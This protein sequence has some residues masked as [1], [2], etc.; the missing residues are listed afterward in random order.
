MY[1]SARNTEFK[2]IQDIFYLKR[3]RPE[4]SQGS[5]VFCI[6]AIYIY[7]FYLVWPTL[8]SQAPRSAYYLRCLHVVL[9]EVLENKA[10]GGTAQQGSRLYIGTK[11]KSMKT[12]V[13]KAW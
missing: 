2:N 7:I 11:E 6:F 5:Q 10:V 13:E 9:P 1:N 4:D 8:F 3:R 12:K